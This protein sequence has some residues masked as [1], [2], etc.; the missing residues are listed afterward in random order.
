MTRS[1]LDHAIQASF[2]GTLND[3]GCIKLRAVLKSDPAARA[4]YYEY[5]DL[6]QSLIFR[7]SRFTTFDSAKSLADIRL[8]LQSRRTARLAITAAAAALIILGVVLKLTLIPAPP[9]ATYRQAPGSLY[10]IEHNAGKNRAPGELDNQSIVNLRQGSFEF[11]L[12]NGT[13]GVV[14]APAKFKFHSAMDMRLEQGTAWFDVPAE[15][16]GFRVSTPELVVTDLGTEFGVVSDP[17]AGDE[18]HVLSGLVHVL[19]PLGGEES[20]TAGHARQCGPNRKLASIPVKPGNFLTRLPQAPAS[21]LIVNGNFESGTRPED[22]DFGA[23]AIASLLPGWQFGRD[24]SVSL[25]S[26]GGL[27]GH[28]NG[29]NTIVSSTADVQVGFRNT[30]PGDYEVGTIDDSI[31]QT[32]ATVPGQPYQVGFEM[33]GYFSSKGELRITA[34]V[35]DGIANSGPSLADFP[36]SRSGNGYSDN[37][38][39]P[40]VS[41]TFTARSGLTTLVLTE[42]SPETAS[43]SPAI[44]N[45]HVTALP[46]TMPAG[47]PPSNR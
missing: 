42:T 31:W 25:H 37:G 26:K 22:E 32:F 47:D 14:L 5:A 13:R 16:K 45:V 30:P 36:E 7:I 17:K 41:F 23:K 4:L 2:D 43:A 1:E 6:H 8:H 38:Y 44:D 18:V 33:G 20:L 10:T 29:R 34:T 3:A 9:L 40:P 24:V 35:Y 21:N 39:N 11:T 46:K 15:G 27:L 12:R 28:G 19:G